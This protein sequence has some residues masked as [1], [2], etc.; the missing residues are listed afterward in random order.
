M[1]GV[2]VSAESETVGFRATSVQYNALLFGL[3]FA[4][5]RTLITLTLLCNYG[6]QCKG[7]LLSKQCEMAT[8]ITKNFSYFMTA[9]ATKY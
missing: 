5:V 6:I 9:R 8:R 3:L 4:T 7:Q 2:W 1:F